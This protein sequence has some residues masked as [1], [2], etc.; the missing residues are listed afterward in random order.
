MGN[1]CEINGCT[2]SNTFI[3]IF[4]DEFLRGF[5]H[6][7]SMRTITATKT[8]NKSMEYATEKD[9]L[10]LKFKRALE[11]VKYGRVKEWKPKSK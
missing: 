10:Y 2:L 7:N 5:K 9:E 3:L 4:L 11:D 8:I 6:I 1:Q